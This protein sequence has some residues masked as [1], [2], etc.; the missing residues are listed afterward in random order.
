MYMYIYTRGLKI[1]LIKGDKLYRH[2]DSFSTLSEI[3]IPG[4][5]TDRI[6][7][8][9]HHIFTFL[10]SISSQRHVRK[11]SRSFRVHWLWQKAKAR[12]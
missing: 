4:L 11:K 12:R 8:V 10:S 2:I 7:G 5:I 6:P 1:H 3:G 9:A